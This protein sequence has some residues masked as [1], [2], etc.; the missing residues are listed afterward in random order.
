LILKGTSAC[1]CPLDRRHAERA[2]TWANDVELSRMLD[3]AR[4]VSDVEH[5]KWS[6]E[7]YGHDDRVY[8]AIETGEGRH[9]GNIWLWD[10]DARHRKAEV[11]IVIGETQ[12]LGRG[13]GSEAIRLLAD[14]AGDRLN[15][16]RLY[17]YVLATNPRARRA[18]EKAGFDLEG[19]LRQD[20][21]VGDAYADVFALG[22]LVPLAG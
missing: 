9:V 6:A 11:R 1:L 15:L 12:A 4:P 5:E 7:L 14:Y 19:V 13:L 22:R 10:V 8:F 20:R 18:F 17:A 2:R 21:W 16:R 3:R